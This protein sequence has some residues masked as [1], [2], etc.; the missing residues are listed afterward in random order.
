MKTLFR[1]LDKLKIMLIL[2]FSLYPYN[3]FC[4][5]KSTENNKFIISTIYIKRSQ[6]DDIYKEVIHR[7]TLPK[8]EFPIINQGAAQEFI[9]QIIQN[10]YSSA[11]DIKVKDYW[12]ELYLK[13][14]ND[15]PVILISHPIDYKSLLGNAAGKNTEAGK[16]EILCK[17]SKTITLLIDSL[18]KES[19]S[20]I[21]KSADDPCTGLNK[22]VD[23]KTIAKNISEINQS[24]YQLQS[25]LNK[26]ETELKS[27][28]EDYARYSPKIVENTENTLTYILSKE[29]DEWNDY[30]LNKSQLLIVIAGGK[31]DLSNA[32]LKI[33]NMP[34]SFQTSIKELE[35]LAG[36]LGV[37]AAAKGKPE[38]CNPPEINDSIP[39]KFILINKDEIKAPSSISLTEEKSKLNLKINNH[40][41]ALFGITVGAS[42]SRLDRKN[43][44]IDSQ[45]NLTIKTDSIQQNELK[46]NLMVMLDFYPAGRD[47]DRLE[48]IWKNNNT[49][50]FFNLNRFAITAGLKLSK[51]PLES[52]FLGISYALT[53][54]FSLAGGIAFNATPND[55]QDLP[56]GVN[57]SLD[58]LKSN[59]DR[60]LVPSW[61]IGI[62]LSPGN[63]SKA[64][65]YKKQD[66]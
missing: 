26:V 17:K 11:I 44:N 10:S 47:I 30:L 43:F 66:K 5:N 50:G 52:C 62:T 27:V 12:N 53:K 41:K 21:S 20:L 29:R 19:A 60:S 49:I 51:D 25:E 58:Y 37:T 38:C 28:A 13:K 45:N 64:L 6:L 1:L 61:F 18:S 8:N 32:T 24:V 36:Q 40:E 39:V 3:S 22:S 2:L 23:I 57:A 56:V 4:Q 34:S 48:P 31:N 7:R 15:Y 63:M 46:G 33:E 59:A 16:Y 55:V 54:E 35:E 65:G 9:N 14:T 42:A